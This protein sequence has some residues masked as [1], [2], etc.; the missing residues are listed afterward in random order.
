MRNRFYFVL[1][2][3]AF[4]PFKM[5]AE[6]I[7][8]NNT[9]TTD[10][11][12]K[13]TLLSEDDNSTVI[14]VDISGFDVK[15]FVA[16]GKSFQKLDLFTDTWTTETGAP[17]I[18][19]IAK[20][21][22]IPDNV[23]VSVDI[24][25]MGSIQTFNNIDLPPARPSWYEGDPEPAYEKNQAVYQSPETFPQAYAS[26]DDPAV[27]RDFRIARV[28]VFPFRYSP[29]K[30]ELEACS[31]ITLRINYGHGNVINPK[32][33]PRRKIAPSFAKIYRS[34]IFN[35][36]DVLNK[37]YGGKEDGEELMLCIM[38]DDFTESFQVYADWK[39]QSGTNIHITKF[40]DIGATANNPETIKNHIFDAY[41]TWP[42]IPTYVLI[43][44]DDGVFPTKTITYPD[45]SS[46]TKITSLNW[47]EMIFSRR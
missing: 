15:N 5:Q 7:S 44:G 28:S 10:T 12:P 21:L 2:I 39:R 40:S 8:L 25:E 14:K 45:Y 33:T 6:W 16:S 42:V 41:N 27:F 17:E 18:P 46:P 1:L 32:S 29:S 26:I 11:S 20:V 3:A 19:Y 35:Y 31:S 30:Q 43:V 4:L 36:Q 13:V 38:P 34:F 24:L 47:K 37:W 22:A 9:K 23:S